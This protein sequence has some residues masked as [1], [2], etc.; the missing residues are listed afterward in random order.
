MLR[1]SQLHAED[2]ARV[3]EHLARGEYDKVHPDLRPVSYLSLQVASALGEARQVLAGRDSELS[4]AKVSHTTA[5]TASKEADSNLAAVE[6]ALSACRSAIDALLR[7]EKEIV[8]SGAAP[9][10]LDGIDAQLARRRAELETLQRRAELYQRP[11]EDAR[12]DLDRAA[13]RLREAQSRWQHT[14]DKVNELE[15]RLDVHALVERFAPQFRQIVVERG[16]FPSSYFNDLMA[17]LGL[18]L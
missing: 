16:H 17:R 6:E 4:R 1:L 2:Q 5:A 12:H 14:A 8:S 9:A 7:E 18:E 3:R 13:V 10:A 15:A 11:A